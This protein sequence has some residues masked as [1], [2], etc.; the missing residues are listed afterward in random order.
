M[1][2]KGSL[3]EPTLACSDPNLSIALSS[4]MGKGSLLELTLACSDPN[5]TIALVSL[6]K[7]TT[8]PSRKCC[9]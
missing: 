5:P 1:M 4:M 3:L 2:E 8:I 7:G 9:L 6:V